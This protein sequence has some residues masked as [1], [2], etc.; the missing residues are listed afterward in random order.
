MPTSIDIAI[1]IILHPTDDSILIALRKSDVHLPDMWEFP[2]GKCEPGEAPRDAVVRESLEE[3]GLIVEPVE[4][5]PTITHDYADRTVTL[6]PFLCR[7]SS[8]DAKPLGNSQVKW[9]LRSELG[10]YAF[11]PANASL[12]MRLGE[13]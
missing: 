11:P 13:S 12:L 1:A 3:V 2:G 6:H 4:E 9:V 10:G 8:S 5:W 7:A